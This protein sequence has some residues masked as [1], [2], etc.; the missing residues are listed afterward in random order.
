MADRSGNALPNEATYEMF[1][2]FMAAQENRRRAGQGPNTDGEEFVDAVDDSYRRT[3]NDGIQGVSLGSQTDRA[4][5]PSLLVSPTKSRRSVDPPAVSIEAL[6]Q[7]LLDQMSEQRKDV[8]HSETPGSRDPE[9][10]FESM[11]S[12][13]EV[14]S[15]QADRSKLTLR[16]CI[17]ENPSQT[18]DRPNRPTFSE[19][20]PITM[21]IGGTPCTFRPVI[22]G[23]D[24]PYRRGWTGIDQSNGGSKF[25]YYAVKIG[26]HP[27]I[28]ES[29]PGAWMRIADFQRNTR[30]STFPSGITPVWK[31][32]TKYVDAVAFLGWDPDVVEDP[33]ERSRY[34]PPPRTGAFAR[35]FG[36]DP[37]KWCGTLTAG[38]AD[39]PPATVTKEA[40]IYPTDISSPTEDKS[41][42]K[43][44]SSTSGSTL[45]SADGQALAAL[46]K[47][48]DK[49]LD[50]LKVQDPDKTKERYHAGI[51]AKTK[52]SDFPDLAKEPDSTELS[53][54]DLSMR[55]SLSN[56]HWK[57]SKQLSNSQAK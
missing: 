9:V 34:R 33:H 12:H 53:R 55:S 1:L 44:T 16:D 13:I 52:A 46:Q 2:Q 54:W 14:V 21:D 24:H 30:S 25:K 15:S 49:F 38:G 47:V 28:Y 45:P 40:D 50:H 36:P 22:E 26:Y 8:L 37:C 57:V 29:Q 19:Y 4:G 3:S 56:T 35:Q 20:G 31:G 11:P 42:S 32:F 7:K 23:F 27:G 5:D 51:L 43:S 18:N 10:S 6:G 48:T 41:T 39:I 17:E